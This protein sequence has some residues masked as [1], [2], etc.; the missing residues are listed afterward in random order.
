MNPRE[1]EAGLSALHEAAAEFT[2]AVLA[3]P[4]EAWCSECAPGKWSPSEITEHLSLSYETHLAELR[5]GPGLRIRIKGIKRLL[6]RLLVL[7]KLLRTGRFPRPVRAPGEVAPRNPDPDRASA[8]ARFQRVAAEFET[9]LRAR[10]ASGK[11][12]LTHPF[13][14]KLSGEQSLRFVELHVRHHRGQLPVATPTPRLQES[15]S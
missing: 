7:P 6:L 4:E 12:G 14:G 15:V 5:G 11:G 9:E 3:T 2:E 1:M 10:L 13:F 8:L